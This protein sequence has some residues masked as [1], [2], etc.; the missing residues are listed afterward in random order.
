MDLEKEKL[1]PVHSKYRKI[2]S[3]QTNVAR[4]NLYYQLSTINY[5][6]SPIY[7]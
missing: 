5:H 6:Q 7:L 1:I 3:F 4:T 2:K